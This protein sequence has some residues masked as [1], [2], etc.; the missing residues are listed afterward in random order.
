[1]ADARELLQK[2]GNGLKPLEGKIPIIATS[3]RSE[4]A[5]WRAKAADIRR[6]AIPHHRKRSA[7]YSSPQQFTEL[8][9]TRFDCCAWRREQFV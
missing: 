4:P 1:M 7:Q 6:P 9:P 3:K 8:S 5:A 2:I